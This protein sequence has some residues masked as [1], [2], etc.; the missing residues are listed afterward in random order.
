[1]SRR[2]R[3]KERGDQMRELLR[4]VWVLV[5]VVRRMMRVVSMRKLLGRRD[6]NV[7]VWEGDEREVVQ[8]C[9]YW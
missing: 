9:L 5:L 8:L 4:M 6:G 7:V 3:K 2:R 1:M